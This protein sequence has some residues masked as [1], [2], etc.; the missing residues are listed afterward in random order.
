M[1]RVGD[2]VYVLEDFNHK[3][4]YVLEEIIRYFAYVLEDFDHKF[5]YVLEIS[6]IFVLENQSI[7]M[8]PRN[9]LSNL[10]AWASKIIANRL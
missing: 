9:L 4:A 5:A 8:I 1:R 3:F 7:L 2:F 10:R 6:C